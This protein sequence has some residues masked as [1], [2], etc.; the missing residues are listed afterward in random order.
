MLEL[1]QGWFFVLTL[2]VSAI[3]CVP[4]RIQRHGRPVCAHGELEDA[5]EYREQ[6]RVCEHI[7]REVCFDAPDAPTAADV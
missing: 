3:Q 1:D 5:D 7:A 6:S 2:P 4:V